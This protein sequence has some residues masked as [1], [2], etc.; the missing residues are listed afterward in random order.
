M[1]ILTKELVYILHSNKLTF[2][3]IKKLNI[4]IKKY[5]KNYSRKEVTKYKTKSYILFM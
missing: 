4:I 3:M 2:H 5:N 1:Y